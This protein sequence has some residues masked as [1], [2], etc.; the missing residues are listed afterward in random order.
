MRYDLSPYYRSSVGFDQLFQLLDSAARV[1]ESNS[2]PP[3]NIEKTG[4]DSY[5]ITL[6]VAGFSQADLN[7][8]AQNTALTV[9]GRKVEKDGEQQFLHRGL[10]TRAFE[11]RFQLADHVQVTGASLSDGLLHI[12]LKREVPQ[13]LRPRAISIETG[14]VKTQPTIDAKQMN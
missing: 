13:A 1:E 6:A 5:R 14:G 4:D 10:A 3:Y 12:D 11:R 7:I 8:V 2:Y 9:T